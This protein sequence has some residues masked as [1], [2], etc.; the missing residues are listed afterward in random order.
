MFRSLV[1]LMAICLMTLSTLCIAS[2]QQS[3][4]MGVGWRR[5][6]LNWKLKNIELDQISG[7]VDSHIQFKKLELYMAYAKAKWI[8]SKYYVRLSADYG[9]SFKGEA[10]EHFQLDTPL[11]NKDILVNTH[12][13]IKKRSEVYDFDIATGYPLSF[14]YGR[15]NVVPLIGF[16]FH[17]QHLRVK[18]K[19]D[20]SSSSSYFSPISSSNPL[21]GNDSNP[22]VK[23]SSDS[24]PI[25]A[26][27]LGLNVSRRTSTY[28]FNWY[29][30]YLGTDI[31]YALDKEWTLYA[32]LEAHCLDSCHR[33]R[34]SWTGVYFVDHYHRN[35]WAWGFNTNLGTTFC[36]SNC[37]YGKISLDYKWL[38]SHTRKDE[39]KW[40]SVGIN[41]ALSHSF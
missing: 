34:K 30:F 31:A 21:Y 29:G 24:N 25:I 6:K 1:A 4:E 41:A 17:R 16:S 36:L 19:K 5:D 10:R 12:D 3:V 9:T 11:L 13:P 39:L 38:K 26:N 20:S 18:G 23:P 35:R 15:L 32:E 28:R 7:N 27:K 22:F 14:C 8:G 2:C 33:K 40:E 37:W